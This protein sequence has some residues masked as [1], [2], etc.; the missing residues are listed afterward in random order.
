MLLRFNQK[1]K[2]NKM[3]Q[4]GQ[5]AGAKVTGVRA[6]PLRG[7]TP[8]G[9]WQNEENDDVTPDDLHCLIE[10]TTSVGVG[11]MQLAK[12]SLFSPFRPSW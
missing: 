12:K 6:L 8:D 4:S 2:Q 3:A 1:Q 7:S 5:G 11:G 10:V 9:G